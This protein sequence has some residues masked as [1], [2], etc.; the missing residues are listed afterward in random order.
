MSEQ[1]DRTQPPDELSPA[2]LELWHRVVAQYGTPTAH[3]AVC[4]GAIRHHRNALKEAVQEAQSFAEAEIY[5]KQLDDEQYRMD[6]V[7]DVF[8]THLWA[9][10]VVPD[11]DTA[12]QVAEQLS[13]QFLA[14]WKTDHPGTPQNPQEG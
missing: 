11:C 10:G 5:G 2:Q 6:A 4:V 7:L 14:A 9:T 3:V 1:E 13:Q 8:A 12:E